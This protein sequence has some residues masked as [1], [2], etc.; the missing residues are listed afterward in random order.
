MIDLIIK[1]SLLD[2][3]KGFTVFPLLPEQQSLSALS[4]AL[5]VSSCNVVWSWGWRLFVTM[6]AFSY[7]ESFSNDDGFCDSGCF[8]RRE[9]S[10]VPSYLY[11][12]STLM[13][14]SDRWLRSIPGPCIRAVA[15]NGGKAGRYRKGMRELIPIAIS[16]LPIYSL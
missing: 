12:P 4:Q 15:H 7:D 11:R 16:H 3:A 10:Q 9:Q 14:A 5:C 8:V 13:A 1:T 6:T 2:S